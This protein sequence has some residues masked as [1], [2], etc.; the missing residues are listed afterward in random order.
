VKILIFNWQDIKNPYAGGAEVHLH[1]IFGRIAAKGYSVTL[2]C[3]SFRGAAPQD[4][5]DGIKI[6][7]TGSR[8]TFNFSVPLWYL[9]FGEKY[10]VVVDD[11]NKIPF[12]TPLYIRKPVVTIFHH[13][14][15]RSIWLETNPVA[16]GYVTAAEWF[17]PR[18]YRSVPVIAVSES[19]KKELIAKGIPD[20][21]IRVIYN[22]V[23]HNLYKPGPAVPRKAPAIGFLGRIKKYKSIEHLLEAFGRV[24]VSF[25]DAKLTIIGDGDYLPALKKY[26]ANL[27]IADDTRFTGYVSGEEKVK[28]VRNMDVIVN[29]SSKEGWGLTVL[30]A[31]ACGIPVI[32]SAVSGLKDSILHDETGVLYTYGNIEELTSAIIDLLRNRDKRA[33]FAQNAI[34]WASRFNWDHAADSVLETIIA[35]NKR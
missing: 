26:A 16:A 18:V 15:G 11:V 10:D 3:S 24:K 29:P 32:G 34:K 8:N 33:R 14:F 28:L 13:L 31:N 27:G 9:F 6:Y 19:T 2:V 17:I 21:N 4:F 35:H 25:P 7:R 22:S 23:D 1:E 30:E 12:Y 20:D 5:I